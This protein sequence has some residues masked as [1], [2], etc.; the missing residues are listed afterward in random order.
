VGG[1]REHKHDH[2]DGASLR[3]EGTSLA[4]GTGPNFCDGAFRD[5]NQ[6]KFLRAPVLGRGRPGPRGAPVVHKRPAQTYK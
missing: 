6:R 1:E 4:H 5:G 2:E 3:F